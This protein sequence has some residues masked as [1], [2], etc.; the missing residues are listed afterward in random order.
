MHWCFRGSVL[1]CLWRRH[2]PRVDRVSQFR[3][4][5]QPSPDHAL[6]RENPVWPQ[7]QLPVWDTRSE[8]CLPG[9]HLQNGHDLLEVIHS[10]CVCCLCVWS[11]W[12]DLQCLCVLF[13]CLIFLRWSAAFV[14]VVFVFGLGVWSSWGDL[15]CLCVLSLCLIFLRWS[16]VFVCVVSV[17]ICA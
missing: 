13:L 16:A 7:R 17:S 9:H 14:C 1:D 10:V 6:G 15:Q 8:L 3:P 4:G 2:W 5:R 12:G 11:S